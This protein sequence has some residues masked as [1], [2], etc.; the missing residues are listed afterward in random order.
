MGRGNK[1]SEYP[2]LGLAGIFSTDDPAADQRQ[3]E[4]EQGP[5][6]EEGEY[7]Y[8][9][10]DWGVDYL[11][12]GCPNHAWYDRELFY[13]GNQVDLERAKMRLQTKHDEECGCGAD[14]FAIREESQFG[15]SE[16]PEDWVT[17]RATL[18]AVCPTDGLWGS[19]EGYNPEKEGDLEA[20]KVRLQAKH[21]A[22]CDCG[23]S[24]WPYNDPA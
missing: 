15:W 18:W 13:V 11:E 1:M 3:I 24:L 21:N 10:D 7:G 14:L 4:A 22:F 20:A 9:E 5:P 8:P 17:P 16:P 23:Q 12:A 6:E 2:Y 19:S